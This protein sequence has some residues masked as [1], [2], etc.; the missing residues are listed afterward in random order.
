MDEK[1]NAARAAGAAPEPQA[2]VRPLRRVGSFTLG[3]CL[4]AA[5][6]FFL[7]WYFAPNFPTQL[8][9]KIAP[10]AGLVLL[11]CEVLHFARRPECWKYDFG[12]V[13]IC[14]VLMGGCFC[15]ALLPRVWDEFS[16]ERS[17][18]SNRLSREY[19]TE[20]YAETR[21]AAPDVALKDLYG[22]LYLYTNDVQT[23]QQYTPG[24]GHLSLN[25][26]LFGPYTSAESF[27]QD[28]R[29]LTDAIQNC[30]PQPDQVTFTWEAE[31]QP[32]AALENGAP[33]YIEQ[34]TLKLDGLASL[35]WTA[36]QMAKQTEV[37]SLLDEENKQAE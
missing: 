8:V 18:A 31:N 10:A 35:D 20:V 23:L 34:Y 4:I 12:S 30:G 14:L 5:G 28:C 32:G 3:V 13:F 37:R 27:A 33:Q 7:G 1:N 17:R 25:V 9:L 21:R 6:L 36:D 2:A 24:S 16:P 11:G 19:T 15:L 22:N 26:E 29:T